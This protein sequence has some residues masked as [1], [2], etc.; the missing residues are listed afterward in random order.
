V[1]RWK[2]ALIGG[3]VLLLCMLARFEAVLEVLL[4][5]IPFLARVLPRM[6][7]DRGSV[8]LGCVAVVLF[9]AGVH[10]AG[11]AW[12]RS[13]YPEAKPA[14][15]LRWSLACVGVVFLLFTAGTAVVGIT[16][17]L[18][19]LATSPEPFR[20]PA[21]DLRPSPS[22]LR[23]I[24]IGLV[25]YDDSI[26][27]YPP[28]KGFRAKGAVPHS[29]ET[30]ILPFM[31]IS[32]SEID[33]TAPWN[34]PRNAP[35][36]QT[37]LWPFLNQALP[38]TQ[39]L[40]DEGYGLSHYAANVWVLNPAKRMRAQDIT[41]GTVNTLLVG[42]VN[43][44]FQP[45]GHPVNWRDPARGVNRSPYGFGG[46]PGA[47]GAYFVMAD[48]SV[49]FVSDRVSPEVLRALGTPAGGEDVD[50]SVLESHD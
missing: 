43:A 48:A 42:E 44:R 6:T 40:D 23:E 22:N 16:H 5:W 20:V 35:Y 50:V 32:H 7:V 18:A 29:W 39:L 25:N 33:F 27:G 38:G 46:A 12:W 3:G 36:F 1:T 11:R 47:G 8:V 41:D 31:G 37:P 13:A 2:P 10:A 30:H 9:T 21:V 19:W 26:D 49:R 17:Q 34:D 4:G 15:K 28:G 14:W 45:W 24:G